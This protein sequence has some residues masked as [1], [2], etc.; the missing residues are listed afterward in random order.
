[1]GKFTKNMS[2]LQKMVAVI[3][4]V[5]MVPIF[6][7]GVLATNISKNALENQSGSSKAAIASQTAGMIDQEMERINQLFLQITTGTSFQEAVTHLKPKEGLSDKEIA[8]WNLEKM[9][10]FK[11]LDKDIQSITIANKFISSLSLMFVSG[12]VVGPSRTL[13]EGVN[14]VRKTKVYQR[15]ITSKDMIWLEKDIADIMVNS[16]YLAVGKAVKSFYYSDKEPVAAV[17]LELNYGAF[18][19]MLSEIKIGEED[20]S[21]IIAGNKNLISSLPYDQTV[22]AAKNPVFGEVLIRAASVDADAFTMEVNGVRSIVTYDKGNQSGLVFLMVIPEAEVFRGAV[23]IRNLILMVGIT[24]SVIAI[25]GGLYFS[26]NMT[27][28]LKKV[29]KIMSV[30]AKG[31]LTVAA[32]TKRTDEIGKVANSFNEMVKSIR[33]LIAQSNEVSGRVSAT[34]EELTQ[35][36]DASTRSASE[37]SGAIHDVAA[38]AGQQSEEVERSVQIFSGLAGEIN[39]AV[40]NTNVMVS[41]AQ[42]VKNYTDEGIEAAKILDGKALEVISITSEVV[43]QIRG[44]EKSISY[45]NEFTNILSVTSEQTQL[46]SLN[47]SIEAARA[48]EHGKG[49]TVVADEIR[50]LA[51]QSGSQAK[52]I[53]IL[54]DEI[55]KQTQASTE[56]IMKA[57][58][59]IKEQAETAKDSSRYFSK[60]D[61]AMNELQQNISNIRNVIH[62]IDEGKSSVLN[63]ISNIAAV[64]QMTAASSEEVSASTQEQLYSLEE[65]TKMAVLLNEHSKRLEETLRY[66]IL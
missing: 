45:I 64:S 47:A 10:Y 34:A 35:I 17:M 26:L 61:I 38:G 66:F 40:A 36:S 30:S 20:I 16:S 32:Q 11:V 19:S 41:A 5:V 4:S 8:A 51:Q 12:D 54:A 43:R 1:M 6:I 27:K 31:D 13:P 24:F 7:I 21:Y 53:E 29:E 56:F 9:K 39:Q 22:E 15:L 44:L 62:R 18:Q 2:L 58:H 63:R 57:N 50:K 25:F 23:E 33:G 14:D 49:F 46:L 42:K 3:L 55:L 52:K 37:I 65:L 60:I 48:G 28:A 59:V